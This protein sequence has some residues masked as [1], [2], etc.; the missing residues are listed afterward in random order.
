LPKR[1][2]QKNE[3]NSRW[4]MKKTQARD[5]T[6]I[7]LVEGIPTDHCPAPQKKFTGPSKIYYSFN[8]RSKSMWE[9]FLS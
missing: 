6:V 8:A 5:L 1:L 9:N 4:S 3:K 2:R 7:G